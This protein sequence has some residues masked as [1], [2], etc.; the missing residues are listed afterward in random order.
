MSSENVKSQTLCPTIG[1]ISTRAIEIQRIGEEDT[2]NFY[3]KF[4]HLHELC[5]WVLSKPSY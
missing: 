1:D 5:N 2:I 3:E 4:R